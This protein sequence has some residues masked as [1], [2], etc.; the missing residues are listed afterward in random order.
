VTELGLTYH[1]RQRLREFGIGVDVVAEIAERPDVTHKNTLGEIVCVADAHPDWT[2]VLG[3]DGVVITVLRRLRERWEHEPVAR[4]IPSSSPPS[5]PDVGEDARELA[6]PPARAPS[7]RRRSVA[8]RKPSPSA[9]VV[10]VDPGALRAA[11][12]LAG[13]D[14]RRLQL[15]RDGT[16][17]VLNRPRGMNQ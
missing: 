16:V 15:N 13:G 8:A 17:T 3:D 7:R 14:L 11:T 9:V 1:A 4:P 12:E 6:D 2:V 5:T 10:R